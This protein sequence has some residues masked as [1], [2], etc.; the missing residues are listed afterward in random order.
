[1]SYFAKASRTGVEKV[2]VAIAST[3]QRSAPQGVQ[4][5]DVFACGAGVRVRVDATAVSACKGA[6]ERWVL[7]PAAAFSLADEDEMKREPSKA[8]ETLAYWAD[9]CTGGP[10]MPPQKSLAFCKTLAMVFED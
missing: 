10:Q 3:S 8:C 6:R 7:P 2:A 9:A 5:S 4:W 1:M